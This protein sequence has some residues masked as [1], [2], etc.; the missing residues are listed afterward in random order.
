MK[1]ATLAVETIERRIAHADHI[2]AGIPSERQ[3]ADELGLSRNTVRAA[4]QHLVEKGV[5]VR[6][7][8]GRLNVALQPDGANRRTIGFIAPAG[9]SGD[10][11]EWRES[12]DGVVH[13]VLRDQEVTV[14][15][16][17]YGHWG[18]SAIQDALNSFD[19]AFFVT[20]AEKMPAWLVAK[21]KASSCRVVVLDQDE[22]AAGLP[23]LTLF[24]P[25]MESK[26]FDH[27]YRLGHRQI[28]CVNTQE[29]GAVVQG[30]ISAWRRY[31]ELH[32]L[33]GQLRSLEK[34]K[35]AES[36]YRLISD[37]L[38]EG[39][40]VASALFCTTGPA[41]VGAIRALHDA[42]LKVGRDVSVCAV[43]SEG[44]GRYLL[45]SLTALEAPPRSLYLRRAGEWMLSAGAWEGPL[46]LQPEDI[47]MFEGESTGPAP[48]FGGMN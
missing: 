27:L 22:S 33:S 26:L 16:V 24:P 25:A 20:P 8:N 32:G 31:L 3:L 18:D 4:V 34:R 1:K 41:A 43:N 11:D 30:R 44:L 28:D 2:V 38:Q 9:P 29:Q 39:Q 36:A 45:P 15:S 21:I 12:V 14:R 46:L 47:P 35:P 19:G 42:G 40:R 5:L 10:L 48:A 7:S 37:A 13:G 23:S 17:S 6:Q